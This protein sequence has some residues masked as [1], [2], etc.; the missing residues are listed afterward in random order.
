MFHYVQVGLLY[1]EESLQSILDMTFDWTKEEREMLRR[2]VPVTGFKTPFRDGYVRDLAEE[3]LK[4]A[5]V[6][7]LLSL[8]FLRTF[9]LKKGQVHRAS[10]CSNAYVVLMQNGLERRGYKEVGFLRE[11]EETVG[12]GVTPAERLLNLYET[13]WQRNVDHVFEHLLY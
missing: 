13:K 12:T 8:C 1:D 5:K 11:V 7:T 6:S 2:K 4:L 10:V 9:S 3:V